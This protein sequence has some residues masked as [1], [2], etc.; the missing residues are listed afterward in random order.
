MS[1]N[2]DKIETIAF[3]ASPTDEAEAARQRLTEIYGSVP[4]ETAE[5]KEGGSDA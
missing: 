1:A 4:A 5:T 3:V 2:D